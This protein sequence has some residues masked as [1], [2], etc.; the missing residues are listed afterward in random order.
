MAMLEKH[1]S[2]DNF[3]WNLF[4]G[5]FALAFFILFFGTLGER[6][7]MRFLNIIVW[8]AI[9]GG[10]YWCFFKPSETGGPPPVTVKFP[11]PK[12]TEFCLKD[13]NDV[14]PASLVQWDDKTLVFRDVNDKLHVLKVSDLPETKC[15]RG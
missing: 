10:V 11:A 9:A 1:E 3:F 13:G 15:V 2:Q 4:G 8:I 12:Q 5:F 7:P 14:I 6:K